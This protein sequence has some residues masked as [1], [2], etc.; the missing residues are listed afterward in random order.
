MDHWE[1]ATLE[2][3]NRYVPGPDH[4]LA[5]PNEDE[6]TALEGGLHGCRNDDMH[7]VRREGDER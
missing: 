6:I 5:I 7:R 4:L 3:D 1:G 2:P